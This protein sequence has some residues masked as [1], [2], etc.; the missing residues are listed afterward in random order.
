MNRMEEYFRD[1]E[2]ETPRV[3]FFIVR[4]HWDSFQVGR[5]LA[6]AILCALA[7][8]GGPSLIRCQTIHGSVVYLR[9]DRVISVR[10]CTR[11]QRDAQRRFWKAID[12]EDDTYG[13]FDW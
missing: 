9:S 12:E 5:E 3:D 11:A 1:P 2:L 13:M 8:R 7:R 10:E 6:E 4:T